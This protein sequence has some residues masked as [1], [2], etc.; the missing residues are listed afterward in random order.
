MNVSELPFI[1]DYLNRQ[2]LTDT[3]LDHFIKQA[4]R[5]SARHP[6]PENGEAGYDCGQPFHNCRPIFKSSTRKLTP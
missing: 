5:V 2:D 3:Q 6:A 4:E 1:A